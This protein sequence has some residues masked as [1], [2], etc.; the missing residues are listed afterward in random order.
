MNKNNKNHCNSQVPTKNKMSK[1]FWKTGKKLSDGKQIVIRDGTLLGTKRNTSTD[2]I[3]VMDTK[4]LVSATR[5]SQYLS[6]YHRFSLAKTSEKLLDSCHNDSGK[7]KIFMYWFEKLVF[8]SLAGVTGQKIRGKPEALQHMLTRKTKQSKVT[9]ILQSHTWLTLS[10]LREQLLIKGLSKNE[11]L[12]DPKNMDSG[13]SYLACQS[14]D[15][16]TFVSKSK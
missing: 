12:G 6:K 11:I 14:F 2:R 13:N 8:Q 16:M 1:K 3:I 15:N 7:S 5:N 4:K 9:L 10:E